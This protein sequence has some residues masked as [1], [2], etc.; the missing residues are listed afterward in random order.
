MAFP[1]LGFVLVLGNYAA[2]EYADY[3]ETRAFDQSLI[4]TGFGLG[5]HVH[6]EGSAESVEIPSETDRII[7][8]D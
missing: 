2:F 7:R 1:P 8:S 5:R 3:A 4:D 6:A